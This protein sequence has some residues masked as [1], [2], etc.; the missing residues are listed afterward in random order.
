MSAKFSNNMTLSKIVMV[1]VFVYF[2]IDPRICVRFLVLPHIPKSRISDP[3]LSLY[4]LYRGGGILYIRLHLHFIVR[5]FTSR[6]C[7]QMSVLFYA[8]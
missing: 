7:C 2:L 4:P 3:Y 1:K 6:E 5:K 8:Q